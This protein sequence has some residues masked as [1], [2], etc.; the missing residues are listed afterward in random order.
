MCSLAWFTSLFLFWTE[1]KLHLG[2]GCKQLECFPVLVQPVKAG[3]E[4]FFQ[5]ALQIKTIRADQVTLLGGK[6]DDRD[7]DQP[8][9]Y[10]KP[11]AAPPR[12][13]LDDDLPF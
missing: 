1:N 11:L 9:G 10:S 4:N 6:R 5:L 3:S 2:T 8:G 13:D 7:D 12:N